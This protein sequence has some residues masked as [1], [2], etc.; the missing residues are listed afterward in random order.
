MEKQTL[1][2]KLNPEETT[3]LS[4][5]QRLFKKYHILSSLF[6]K[7]YINFFFFRA[8]TKMKDNNVTLNELVEHFSSLAV[9]SSTTK[10][11][12]ITNTFYNNE[13]N[14]VDNNLD[15]INFFDK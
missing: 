12:T 2:N 5:V 13:S 11:T 6:Y 4:N 8:E 1:L 7:I 15:D 14:V 9:A 3:T 10:T